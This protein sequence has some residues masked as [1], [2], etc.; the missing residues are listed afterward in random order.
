MDFKTFD[1]GTALIKVW[2]SREHKMDIEWPDSRDPA[3]REI[4]EEFG[5]VPQDLEKTMVVL[6]AWRQS[7]T[8]IY[9]N[10]SAVA[11]V[12]RNRSNKG[13]LRSHLL[14][15]D[16]FDQMCDVKAI[17]IHQYP[18]ETENFRMLLKNIDDILEGKVIDVTQGALY[19]GY[20]N[21]NMP[22]WFKEIVNSDKYERTVQA[23]GVT[24]YREKK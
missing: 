4:L 22:E 9:P 18:T 14:D 3:L 23:G 8:D 21:Q 16:Q 17:M 1:K 11:H 7:F 20:I 24:F 5:C 2:R 13:M 15:P 6:A 19:F 12:I 10:M